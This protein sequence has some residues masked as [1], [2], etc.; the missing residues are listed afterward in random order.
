[1]RSVLKAFLLARKLYHIRVERLLMG[2]WLTHFKGKSKIHHTEHI[3]KCLVKFN[4][5][6]KPFYILRI[7]H[8]LPVCMETG[9][10]YWWLIKLY[11][12]IYYMIIEQQFV[13]TTSKG[14][15]ASPHC[16]SYTDLRESLW[17]LW[18]SLW[19]LKAPRTWKDLKKSW[20][21]HCAVC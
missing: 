9:T 14:V 11:F 1:M 3:T 2:A 13:F 4:F 17:A 7:A 5:T 15:H 12:C 16:L 6:C 20:Q 18:R 8:Y 21:T 19:Y 10:R